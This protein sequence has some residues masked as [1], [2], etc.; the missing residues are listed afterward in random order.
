VVNSKNK[1]AFVMN[2]TSTK[3]DFCAG[4]EGLPLP[5]SAAI[6]TYIRAHT[7]RLNWDTTLTPTLLLHW[8]IGFTQNWLGR[9]ALGDLYD[10]TAGLG[11]TGPFTGRKATFPNFTGLSNTQTGGSTNISSTGALADDVFQQGT[12][13]LSLT[14]VKGNHTYKFG[15]ELR[16]QGDYRLDE[17]DVNGN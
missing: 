10:A 9:P 7:E 17:S 11:L 3:C 6:G 4:A 8:G 13:I 5:V 2:R 14:W 12:A 16:N 15:G 1:V